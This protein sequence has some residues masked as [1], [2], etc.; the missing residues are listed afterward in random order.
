MHAS[1]T[2]AAL[3]YL[4]SPSEL[5]YLLA[6]WQVRSLRAV[7]AFCELWQACRTETV[8]IYCGAGMF[9]W[10]VLQAAPGRGPAS[11]VLAVEPMSQNVA[12]MQANLQQHGLASQVAHLGCCHSS[13][14]A[15]LGNI[16]CACYMIASCTTV[17]SWHLG[18]HIP[19][20]KGSEPN[21]HKPASRGVAGLCSGCHAAEVSR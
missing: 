10:W 2:V 16:I 6:L 13:C 18:H 15:L 8:P 7:P 20:L 12:V 9:T 19:Q 5:F 17:D 14:C 4:S 1:T 21:M 11:R 3:A